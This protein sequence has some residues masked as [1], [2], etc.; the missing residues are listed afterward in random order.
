[1]LLATLTLTACATDKT[2]RNKV[3]A[4]EDKIVGLTAEQVERQIAVV[5]ENALSK[6]PGVTRI[7]STIN[8]SGFLIEVEVQDAA[9]NNQVEAVRSEVNGVWKRLTF[10]MN[11]PTVSVQQSR[12][13]K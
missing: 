10:P 9:A 8:D 1:M 5:F 13:P 4:I 11:E 2:P 7:R 3:I 12:V 6:L